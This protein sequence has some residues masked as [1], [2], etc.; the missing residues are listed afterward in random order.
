MRS[1]TRSIVRPLFAPLVGVACL[2]TSQCML[3]PYDGQPVATKSE[4]VSFGGFHLSPSSSVSVLAQDRT[5]LAWLPVVSA[6]SASSPSWEFSDGSVYSWSARATLA[7]RFWEPGSR[8]RGGLARVRAVGS[9]PSGE[10]GL[11]TVERDWLACFGAEDPPTLGGFAARCA[12]DH[13]PEAEITTSDYVPPVWGIADLHAHPATHL[14]FGAGGLFWGSPGLALESSRPEVDLLPC[15]PAKHAGFDA[16]PVRHGQ[17]VAVM[18]GL[19]EVTGHPHTSGADGRFETWPHARSIMHQQMHVAWIRRAFQ[20]GLRLMFAS[21][22]DNQTLTMLWNRAYDF[23]GGP[24]PRFDPE[25]DFASA[26]RQ[27]GFIRDL[28]AANASWMQVVTSA[29]EARRAILAGKLAL[30]LSVELDSLSLDQVRTLRDEGV[31]HIVPIHLAN[32]AFGGAAVHGPTP[33]D[34]RNPPENVFNTA[35]QFLTGSF[36]SV[37]DDVSL[38]YRLGRPRVLHHHRWDFVKGGA[39][40]PVA[41]TDA[42]YAALGYER[43]FAAGHRNARGVDPS[44]IEALMRQG[45][46]IDLSHMSQSSA[47][48]TLALA[49]RHGYPVLSSHTGLRP[50]RGAAESERELLVDHARRLRALGGVIG[51]GTEGEL[52]SDPLSAW[53]AAYARALAVLGGRGLALGTDFN[54][55]QAQMATTARRNTYPITVAQGRAPRWAAATAPALAQARLGARR[56]DGLSDG[57]AHYGMLPEFLQALDTLPADPRTGRP[58][59]SELVDALFQSAEDVLEFWERAEE[60]TLR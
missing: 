44:A 24:A 6:I 19:N 12:S 58:A 31:R 51:F 15:A 35:N 38:R 7:E 23:S 20:G 52:E 34:P 29:A 21:V 13:S 1:V 14:A 30:V 11:I 39:V 50:A 42:E 27:L 54:G 37:V 41:I 53:A 22:T 60:A 46:M 5:T 59:G 16:D 9:T 40:E 17:R 56:F 28:A 36:F 48:D 2:A 55:L 49:E 25:F 45:L 32:N 43:D 8:G 26:R 4:P 33:L 3:N 18:N 57:L 47:A 10:R